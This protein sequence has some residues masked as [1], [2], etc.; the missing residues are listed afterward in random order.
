MIC[1]SQPEET[2]SEG[3]EGTWSPRFW[4][5]EPSLAPSWCSASLSVF[6]WVSPEA[7]SETRI[8]GQEMYLGRMETPVR[9]WGNDAGRKAAPAGCGVRQV[10]MV[11]NRSFIPLERWPQ[12]TRTQSYSPPGSE[13]AGVFIPYHSQLLVE[14]CAQGD[15]GCFFLGTSYLT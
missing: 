1:S 9:E 5:P 7:D 14:R 8:Q 6:S 4:S 12:R 11:G 3:S 10:S 15:E 2:G 13:R